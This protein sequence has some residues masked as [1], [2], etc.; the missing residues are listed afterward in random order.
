M[1]TV[2]QVTGNHPVKLNLALI[3]Q[4][5]TDNTSGFRSYGRK[6][7]GFLA[8]NYPTDFPEPEAVILLGKNG[9]RIKE[10]F[11][12][13]QARDQG[14]SSINGLRPLYYMVKV[15]LSIFMCAS[16]RRLR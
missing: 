12:S 2:N 16:R 14:T 9:F 7:I 11:V 8:R 3:H 6:A 4:R 10:V 5:I 1:I 13:M 15:V